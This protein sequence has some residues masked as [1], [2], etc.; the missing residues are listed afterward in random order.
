MVQKLTISINAQTACDMYSACSRNAFVSSVSAMNTPAGFLSFLGANSINDASQLMT[1][2][3]TY[4]K[5]N[6][7]YFGTD[8]PDKD[9][10]NRYENLDNCNKTIK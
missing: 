5:N 1:M 6:S 8:H 10:V 7:I 2:K 4:S 9:N 3:F